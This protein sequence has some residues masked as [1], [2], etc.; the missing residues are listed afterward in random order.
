[1]TEPQLSPIQPKRNVL[2]GLPQ[3]LKDPAIYPKIHK[4]LIEELATTHSH[5]ELI[6]YAK[7]VA[8]QKKFYGRAEMI[9]KLGF[10]STAQF[11]QWQ[12]IMDVIVFARRKRLK[13][14]HDE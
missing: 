3:Y 9:K 4:L 10:K 7:C 2:H 13:P 11:F 6:N 12:K 14:D 1:M 5:G 8:C